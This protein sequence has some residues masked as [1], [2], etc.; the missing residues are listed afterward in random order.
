MVVSE[1][2][3]VI[4]TGVILIAMSMTLDLVWG[5]TIP[6]RLLYYGIRAPGVIVH[7]CTHVAGCLVMG[8]KIQNVV[9]FSEKGGSVSYN[10]PIIPYIGDVVISM[11]PLFGIPLVILGIT[12]VFQ[13]YSCCYFPTFPHYFDTISSVQELFADILSLFY[14]NLVVHFNIWFFLYLYLTMSLAVSIAPSGQDI[15][16]AAIG[17]AIILGVGILVVWSNI[18][19]A[20]DALLAVTRILGMG[21]SL[22]FV[23][24][25]IAFIVSIPLIIVYSTK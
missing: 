14:Q 6:S 19:F 24:G 9:L 16:N 11:A 21:I 7:E 20:V 12:W 5:R 3:V 17:I 13:T 25:L 22:G 23:F 18:P 1:F 8:A 10:K 15:K 4:V 2:P